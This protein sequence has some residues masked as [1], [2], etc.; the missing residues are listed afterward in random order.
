M[1]IAIPQEDAH[2]FTPYQR[3]IQTMPTGPKGEKRPVDVIG[4]L[5]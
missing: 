4:N 1:K 5:A 2:A 3:T